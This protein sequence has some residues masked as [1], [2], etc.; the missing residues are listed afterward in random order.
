MG[1]VGKVKT[2][3]GLD[4]AV[5]NVEG[6][7]STLKNSLEQNSLAANSENRQMGMSGRQRQILADLL[8]NWPAAGRTKTERADSLRADWQIKAAGT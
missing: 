8:S 2:Q 3:D 4:F 6:N 5:E 7:K 1:G